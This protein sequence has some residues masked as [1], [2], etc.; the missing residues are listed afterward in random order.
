MQLE[1]NMSLLILN[2]VWRQRS[3]L[4]GFKCVYWNKVGW[5]RKTVKSIYLLEEEDTAVF[6]FWISFELPAAL[7]IIN[8]TIHFYS[9]GGEPKNSWFGF[10]F[11][12]SSLEKDHA[13]SKDEPL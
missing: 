10:S 12:I 6:F 11:Q 4:L 7:L 5:A 8:E 3:T 9:L 2:Q 1:T 13:S